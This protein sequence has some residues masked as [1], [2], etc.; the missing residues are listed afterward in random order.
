MK[1]AASGVLLLA[2]M[3]GI[4]GFISA[5]TSTNPSTN[6]AQQTGQRIGTIISSAI[7]T[8]LPIFGKVMDLFKGGNRTA[9]KDD[10]QNA[11]D[12]AKRDVL[13]AIKQKISPT[14]SV[15]KELSVIQ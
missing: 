5:Q 13:G 6:S 15:A 9:N 12:Q 14:A 10:V 1:R 8:A 4:A 11:T 7:D 2:A 3:L